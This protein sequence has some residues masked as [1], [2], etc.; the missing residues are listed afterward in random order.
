ML[1]TAAHETVHAVFDTADLNP[2]SSSPAW[3]SRLIVE[4]T[5]A[6]VF[7]RP[8]RGEGANTQGGDGDC[9]DTRID[10]QLSARLLM[11]APVGF[12]AGAEYCGL[13]WVRQINYEAAHS[14]AIHYGTLE[15]VDEMDRICR[16]HPDPWEAA[17]VIAAAAHRTD[18]RTGATGNAGLHG[19]VWKRR[20]T[21]SS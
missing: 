1:H 20:V 10:R 12:V 8:Y 6:A 2:Y 17:H 16:E 18:R 9:S 5:T 14:I 4:E 7:G 13:E 21:S 15:L 19:G 11:F 3:E